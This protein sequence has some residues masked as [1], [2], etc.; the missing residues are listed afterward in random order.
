MKFLQIYKKIIVIIM[1]CTLTLF[2]V[3][4][5][6]YFIS[7]INSKLDYIS[8][9]PYKVAYEISKIRAR[10]SEK[11]LTYRYCFHKSVIIYQI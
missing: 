5:T 3:V 11:M 6:N 2:Y 1:V 4:M 9:H 8:D 10:I 7:D